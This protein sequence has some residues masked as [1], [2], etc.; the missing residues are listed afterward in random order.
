M[1]CYTGIVKCITR[2]SPE[3]SHLPLQDY[4]YHTKCNLNLQTYG[5]AFIAE[6]KAVSSWYGTKRPFNQ[7]LASCRGYHLSTQLLE[8]PS[9]GSSSSGSGNP[10]PVTMRSPILLVAISAIA[11]ACSLHVRHASGNV[12]Y[13]G[14]ERDGLEHFYGIPYAQDTSGENRFKPP[15]P[16]VPAP[17]EIVDATKPGVACPQPFGQL[18]PPIG[19]GNITAVSEDCLS[20]NVVRPRLNG[21]AE[22][23]PVMVWIHGGK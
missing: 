16:Y 11:A 5:L 19:L 9:P 17:G 7:P 21:T 1:S 10:K 8:P 3:H 4:D 23:L 20:L 18:Y 12:T 6:C 15:R 13:R 14:V 22:K 2:V